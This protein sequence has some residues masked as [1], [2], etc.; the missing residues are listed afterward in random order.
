MLSQLLWCVVVIVINAKFLVGLVSL[1]SIYLQAGLARS[2]HD[3]SSLKLVLALFVSGSCGFSAIVPTMIV[4]VSSIDTCIGCLRPSLSHLSVP[5]P[6]S[7]KELLVL[8]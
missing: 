2:I 3:V 8:F 1:V 5:K 6:M 7:Y 4:N